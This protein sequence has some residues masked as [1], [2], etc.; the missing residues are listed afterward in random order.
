MQKYLN[1]K[2]LCFLL[3]LVLPV[4]LQAQLPDTI[5]VNKDSVQQ[6]LP[7]LTPYQSLVKKLLTDNQYLS[8]QKT[9]QYNIISLKK[10]ANTSFPFYLLLGIISFLAV[11]KFLYSKY[12]ATLFKV[13]F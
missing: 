7:I 2:R 12:F 4:V 11:V 13:F 10:P 8:T 9:P 1:I 3:L 6:A 5:L